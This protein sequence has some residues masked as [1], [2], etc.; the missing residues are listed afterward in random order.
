MR[1]SGQDARHGLAYEG[2]GLAVGRVIEVAPDDQ[3]VAEHDEH[4]G[5]TDGVRAARGGQQVA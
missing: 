1:G 5:G 4:R 3:A 2:A